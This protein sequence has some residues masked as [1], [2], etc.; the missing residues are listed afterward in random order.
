MDGSVVAAL[1]AACGTGAGGCGAITAAVLSRRSAREAA[2]QA[3]E[4]GKNAA[5][6]SA[7]KLGYDTLVFSV[8]TLQREYERLGTE[9]ATERQE[10]KAEA[11][12]LRAEIDECHAVRDA[13]ALQ[14]ARLT[15][16]A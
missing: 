9:L 12:G 11:A 1:V 14:L 13:Q 10:R 5:A 7:S 8:T 15:N 6:A 4:A 3:Q 16:G 2:S